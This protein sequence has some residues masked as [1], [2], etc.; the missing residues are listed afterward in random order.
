MFD[1]NGKMTCCEI[2]INHRFRINQLNFSMD[3]SAYVTCFCSITYKSAVYY[4]A[5]LYFIMRSTCVAADSTITYKLS[6]S[7]TFISFIIDEPLRA[8]RC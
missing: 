4:F 8:S 7:Y 6:L 2:T 3:T 5:C 1:A